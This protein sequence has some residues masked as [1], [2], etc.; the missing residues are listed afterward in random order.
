MIEIGQFWVAIK[1][2]S[3][4]ET[5]AKNSRVR[6]IHLFYLPTLGRISKP[7]LI[8]RLPFRADD[9]FWECFPTFH[10]GSFDSVGCHWVLRHGRMGLQSVLVDFHIL[11]SSS[12]TGRNIRHDRDNR[13][14]KVFLKVCVQYVCRNIYFVKYSELI[15]ILKVDL[16]MVPK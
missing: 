12:S 11:F 16:T 8:T 9:V 10:H 4:L 1:V 14:E 7:D 15:S 13:I 6:Q 2:H 5:Q 3:A